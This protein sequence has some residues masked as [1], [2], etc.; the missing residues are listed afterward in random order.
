V[1]DEPNIRETLPAIL[2]LHG[3]ETTAVATVAQAVAAIASAPFD[4]LIADLNIGQPGDGFTVVSAMRRTHPNC[5]TFILIG[6]PGFETALQAIRDQVDDYLIKPAQIHVLVDTINERLSKRE[7]R[8]QLA[9]KRV[10]EAIRENAVAI[11]ERTLAHM[12][13]EPV[14]A[15]LPLPDDERIRHI[16]LVLDELADMLDWANSH[17]EVPRSASKL[18][19]TRYAQGFSV[20]LLIRNMRLLE[21]AI[22]EVVHEN[23][24]SLNLSFLM[25][26][27]RRLNESISLALEEV[28]RAYQ[29][30]AE[31]AA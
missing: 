13:T 19:K 5:V 4:V 17:I 18:G 28:V 30:E 9:T 1:D 25:N 27:L 24:L 26:D 22:Y 11:V 16:P 20:P 21:S 7:R 2:H 8:G 31:R 29:E 3:F 6:Y 15:V 23:L 12:K 10:S 14:M